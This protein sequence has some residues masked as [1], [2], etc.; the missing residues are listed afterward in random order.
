MPNQAG[1]IIILL[2]MKNFPKYKQKIWR[3]KPPVPELCGILARQ[4]GISPITSQLLINRGV[5]TSEQG[6]AFIRGH[7]DNLHHPLL[8]RDMAIAVDRIMQAVRAGERVLVYGDYDTDG[9]TSAVLLTDLLRRLGAPADYFLP[10]RLVEGYGVHLDVLKQARAAGTGLVLT[11]DCGIGALEEASWARANGLDLIITD[12]HE[13]PSELPRALAVINPR[14]PDCS[15][16]FKELAGVGVALKLAQALL[17]AAGE[18]GAWQDY[19][20]LVCLGTI[21]D[22]MPILGEN[23]I[24]V[25]HGLARLAATGRPG[26]RA[27]MEVSGIGKELGPREVGFGLAPRLNAAGRVGSPDLAARLLLTESAGE[28]AELALQLNRANQERQG[29]EAE[30]FKEAL[31]LLETHDSWAEDRVLVL[32]SEKWHPGVIGIVAS[33]LLDRFY[34]PVL[35][36][37]LE[38]GE[39]RGSARSIPGFNIHQALDHCREHLLN[40]GG[41]ALAAGFSIDSARIADFRREINTYAR[42]ALDDRQTIPPVYL[43]SIIDLDQVSEELVKEIDLLG[44]FG[45]A[46]PVPLLGC[47]GAPV[48]D[49]RG[50]GKDQAHLKLRLRGQKNILDGIGF[51]LGAFAEVLATAEQQVDLVFRPGL[52]EYNGRRSVQLEVKELGLPALLD[53]PEGSGGP[54]FLSAHSRSHSEPA[55][56][57][58]NLFLPEY[59]LE[60]MYGQNAFPEH[61]AAE[62]DQAQNLELVECGETSL[63]AEKIAQLAAGGKAALIITNSACQVIELAHYLQMTGACP[64]EKMIL[65]TGRFSGKNKTTPAGFLKDT[66]GLII[67][68]P[69]IFMVF[70]GRVDRVL[71]FSLPFSPEPLHRAVDALVPGGRLALLHHPADLTENLASLEAM[72][73][74]RNY[75]AELYKYLHREGSNHA[76]VNLDPGHAARFLLEAGFRHSRLCTVEVGLTVMSELG[77]LTCRREGNL[78][79]LKLLPA[80]KKRELPEA[81]TFRRVHMFKEKSS[82]WMK[83]FHAT[84]SL[85]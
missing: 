10:N 11:V 52:N 36:I 76:E 64:A 3:V 14:R 32:A 34:R 49:C 39:G 51:H 29:L 71:V 73:P 77:L 57:G 75:L 19:L 45:H 8:L 38:S 48:L 23:R 22:I 35:L 68:T 53:L 42:Q 27:L 72:A 37:A 62:A 20:D 5:F 31:N 17:E 13:P 4:L 81:Q 28:A 59:V 83:H 26:L 46:N 63:K 43:D 65:W 85:S 18:A 9:I 69:S 67:A 79:R 50:V 7:L 1:S 82:A 56:A 78:A 6:R 16:P 12:H 60:A 55:Q 66:A 33:R 74:D 44:P 2:S 24:L 21:A 70:T 40:F 54:G 15:Y 47:L 41:H 25:K 61:L 30:V 58:E 84:R 80:A